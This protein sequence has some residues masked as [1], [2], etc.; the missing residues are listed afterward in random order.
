MRDYQDTTK[1]YLGPSVS[2]RWRNEDVIH[3]TIKFEVPAY[4]TIFTLEH[5]TPVLD[6]FQ[7]DILTY[8]HSIYIVVR[9]QFYFISYYLIDLLHGA[10]S[11][12][13]DTPLMDNHSEPNTSAQTAQSAANQTVMSQTAADRMEKNKYKIPIYRIER[14]I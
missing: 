5:L 1:M 7:F 12:L 9:I 10:V 4:R 8:I 11:N 6:S 13:V 3:M 2:F 14:P